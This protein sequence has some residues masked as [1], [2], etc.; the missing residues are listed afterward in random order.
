[1][2]VAKSRYRI[3]ATTD[4][5][6]LPRL[7]SVFGRQERSAQMLGH[8]FHCRGIFRNERVRSLEGHP[9]R[10]VKRAPG[11]LVALEQRWNQKTGCSAVGDTLSGVAGD[12]IDMVGAGH[13][14]DEACKIHRLQH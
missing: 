6:A 8:A 7:Q 9:C 3:D 2:F 5:S 13:T 10:I 14:A 1:M 11:M 4:K 12:Q